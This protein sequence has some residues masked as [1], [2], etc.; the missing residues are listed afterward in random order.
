[1]VEEK[2]LKIVCNNKKSR[3]AVSVSSDANQHVK[4]NSNFNN[5]DISYVKNDSSVKC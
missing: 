5:E 2:V 3:L 4:R 1:M